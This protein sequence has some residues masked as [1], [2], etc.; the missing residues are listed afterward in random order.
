MSN[1]TKTDFFHDT[2]TDQ[3]R[4]SMCWLVSALL[5]ESAVA[6]SLLYSLLWIGGLV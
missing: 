4:K 1:I 3:H 5:I 6:V 2:R